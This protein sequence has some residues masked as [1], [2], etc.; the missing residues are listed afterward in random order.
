MVKNQ[1]IERKA[2]PVTSWKGGS[3][4]SF[5]LGHSS[6][7]DELLQTNSITLP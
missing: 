3:L 7:F 6:I 1:G 4:E 5:S 2:R